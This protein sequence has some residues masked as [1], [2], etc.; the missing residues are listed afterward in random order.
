[1]CLTKFLAEDSRREIDF[2][3]LKNL[4]E[5]KEFVKNNELYIKFDDKKILLNEFP[6]INITPL[7]YAQEKDIITQRY[8]I[9]ASE[10]EKGKGFVYSISQ[11]GIESITYNDEIILNNLSESQSTQIKLGRDNSLRD[12]VKFINPDSSLL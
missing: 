10:Y 8:I 5:F 7:K 9:Q 6:A 12:I 1:M 11:G 3:K 4:E 2:K